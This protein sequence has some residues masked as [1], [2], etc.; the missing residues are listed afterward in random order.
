MT[1]QKDPLEISMSAQKGTYDVTVSIKAHSDTV[2]SLWEASYGYVTENSDIGENEARDICF[3]ADITDCISI[4]I[5][6]DGDLSATVMAEYT[7]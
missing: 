4:K 7:E 2:F 5:Y 3:T 1:Y 6:C